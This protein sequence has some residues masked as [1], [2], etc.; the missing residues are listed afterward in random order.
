MEE[1]FFGAEFWVLV[2]F[3]IF[4]AILVRMGAHRSALSAVDMRTD[5]IRTALD[6]AKSLREEAARLLSEYRQRRADAEKEAAG[7]LDAARSE[8]ERLAADAKAKAEEFVT[9]RTRMA[10]DKIRL[11]ETQALADVRAAAAD[12]AADAAEI[13]LAAKVKGQAADRLLETGIARLKSRFG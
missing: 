9:R 2:A 10:E 7:I 12:A 3:L 5:K 6:E 8:A 1:S 13:V 4:V 11:A